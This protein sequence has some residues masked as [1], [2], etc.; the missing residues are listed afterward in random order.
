MPSDL[1]G[2]MAQSQLEL[3]ANTLS[4]RPESMI[5]YLPQENKSSGQLEFTPAVIFPNPNDER[6]FIASDAGS[7]LPPAL[8]KTLTKLPGFSHAS[9]LLPG[10]PMLSSSSLPTEPGVGVVEEVLC[11]IR[12]RTAALSVPLLSGP[13]TVG[14]LLVSPSVAIKTPPSA[15]SGSG[16][17]TRAGEMTSKWTMEDKRHVSTAAQSLSMALMM[18]NERA[19]LKEQNTSFRE[20]LSDSLHQV[21]NPIQA[22]RTYG[23]ILQRQIAETAAQEEL[24]Q[25]QK[26]MGSTLKLLDLA[27]RLMV[28]SDRVVDLLGPMDTL[29]ETM[30]IPNP[31]S[32]VLLPP[33]QNDTD[34]Y[35]SMVLWKDQ[36]RQKSLRQQRTAVKRQ[37]LTR[38]DSKSPRNDD[39]N[40]DLTDPSVILTTATS[41][42]EN[43]LRVL[44]GNT[45]R[46]ND[47]GPGPTR[48]QQ[49]QQRNALSETS[50]SFRNDAS[51]SVAPSYSGYSTPRSQ[52][53]AS[54]TTTAVGDFDLEIVFVDEVLKP[55]LQTYAVIASE[56]GIS[57]KIFGRDDNDDSIDKDLPGVMAAPK[58]LQEAMSN[59][60]DNAFK[61][62][63]LPKNDSPFTQNPNPTVQVRI[64]PNN[65]INDNN[66]NDDK[67]MKPGVTIR[68]EDN[69]PGV[70]EEDLE[71][72]FERGYRS[73]Q[74]LQVNGTG[75]GLP[76]ARAL[77]RRMGGEMKLLRRAQRDNTSGALDGTIVELVLYRKTRKGG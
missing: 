16:T 11:D 1:F 19:F 48:V 17:T 64:F 74:T 5:L 9:S 22:L 49:R 21:K 25:Q 51:S 41:P 60:L 43:S 27:E 12:Y 53:S 52:S 68:V 3:L 4:V 75:I 54:T 50:P 28:Q 37:S 10:Y 33:A 13:Q 40:A 36:Q 31:S 45:G 47:I 34:T 63:K 57:F 38:Q 29:V 23:K 76:I 24:Q 73:Q 59:V 30:A 55:I 61:Y 44:P 35:H 18:D 8:P 46:K 58:S 65:L 62:V 69:G 6:V 26:V 20:I 15:S 42:S 70:P 14:V 67:T 72:V 77:L 32:L 66:T 39:F 56:R 2:R 7:G 71:R